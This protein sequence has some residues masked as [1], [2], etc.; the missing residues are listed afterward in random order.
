MGGANECA[1]H[2]REGGTTEL[3]ARNPQS[4]LPVRQMSLIKYLRMSWG[5]LEY[6]CIVHVSFSVLYFSL[7]SDSPTK[8][9]NESK[10]D[11]ICVL[12]KLEK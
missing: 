2:G 7:A 11:Y 5:S 3:F 4:T 6:Y 10:R 1:R 9:P 12:G 8:T